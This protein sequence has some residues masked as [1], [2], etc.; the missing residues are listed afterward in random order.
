[1]SRHAAGARRE[2][3][4]PS[5]GWGWTGST[6]TCSIVSS[7]PARMPHWKRLTERGY[8]AKLKSVM[9]ILSPIV[10]TTVATGV[11]PGRSPRPGFPGGRS[12]VRAEAAD[13]RTRAPSPPS[14]TSRRHRG[15][16][17]A[18]SAGG[19]PIRRRK[20]PA[21]SSP[22]APRRSCS[23]ACR[24]PGSRTPRR[25]RRE[26]SRCWRGTAPS[27]ARSSRTPSRLPRPTS[28]S[29]ARTVISTT[30]S[31]PRAHRRL[32]PRIAA[33]RATSTTRTCR[34]HGGLLRGNRRGRARLRPLRGSPR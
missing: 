11:Q 32:D 24:A 1:M 34:A 15:R 5:S 19:P 7:R 10:W 8:S 26:S 31:R 27:P 28:R 9:P 33:S 3:L 4:P 23:R 29:A 30:R 20:S 25:S 2:G 21:S 18:S 14:G 13:L 22:I 12:R 17:S 16:R 6:G